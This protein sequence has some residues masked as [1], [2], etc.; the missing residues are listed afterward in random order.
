MSVEM[1]VKCDECGDTYESGQVLSVVEARITAQGEGWEYNHQD[2]DD[3][4]PDCAEEAA[5]N[6]EDGEVE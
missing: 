6:K 5:A 1:T 4:C 3:L 2:G